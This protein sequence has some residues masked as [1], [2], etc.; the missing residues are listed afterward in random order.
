M[1]RPL[2]LRRRY[3]C[4]PA[5]GRAPLLCASALS[6]FAP[7]D[8]V[9]SGNSQDGIIATTPVGGAPIGVTVSNT[10][11][12]KNGFGIRSIDPNVTVCFENSKVIGNGTGVISLNEA[13]S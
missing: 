11:S 12:A 5:S 4:A 6:L 13:V 3:T 1:A 8:S 7:L 10:V 9:S 2:R